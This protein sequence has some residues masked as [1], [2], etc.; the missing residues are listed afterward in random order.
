MKNA[1]A[2]GIYMYATHGLFGPEFQSK[3]EKSSLSEVVVTNTVPLVLY[4]NNL[5]AFTSS[6]IEQLSVGIFL[7]EAIRRVHMNKSTGILESS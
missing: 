6:K 1:G 5:K 7:A 3:L 4:G 2:K